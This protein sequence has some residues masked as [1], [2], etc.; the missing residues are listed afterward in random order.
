MKKHLKLLLVLLVLALTVAAIA[1]T[2]GATESSEEPALYVKSFS[3]SLEN[4]V[5]MNFKV[6]STGIDDPGSITL[7]LWESVPE[8]Y[9]KGSED[10]ELSSEGTETA[11]GYEVFKYTNLAAKDMTKCVY[12]CAY[13]NVDGEE[14]YSAPVKLSI[15]MYAYM[16]KNATNLDEGLVE[17]L[18]GMLDYGALAQTYFNHNTEFL[19]NETV[20]QLSV[21]NGHFEDNFSLGWYFEGQS[22]TLTADP[23]PKGYEFSHWENSAGEDIG[24]AEVLE[25]TATKNDTYTAVYKEPESSEG[26]EFSLNADGESY[27]VTGLGT[28][29]DTDIVITTYNGLPVTA[30]GINA[31]KDEAQITSVTIGNSVTSIGTGAFAFC[32]SLK[33]VNIGNGVTRI[34]DYTFSSCDN[35]TNVTIGNSVTSIGVQA[36]RSCTSL[37]NVTIPDS[38][39]SIGSD[40]FN[41]CE[42]L[43]SVTIGNGVTSIGNTAFLYCYKLVEVI[44]KSSL[45]ITSGATDNGYVGYYAIEVHTGGSKIVNQNNY[46]FYRYGDTNYLIDFAGTETELILPNSYNGESYKIHNYVFSGR[47]NLA[48][49]Y[50]PDNVTSIGTGAFADCDNLTNITIPD[51]VMSIGSY[52]FSGCTNLSNVTIPDGVT[53]ISDHMFLSCDALTSVT[54]PNGVESIGDDAFNGCTS[55][56][57]VTIP[58]NVTSIGNR[59]F[60]N[61]TS[62]TSITI[63]DSV[64]SIGQWA[65]RNCTSLTSVTI[66]NNVTSIGSS[67]FSGCTK[68]T[69]VTF[70]NTSGWWYS[71]DSTATSGESISSTDLSDASTAATYLTS[72]YCSRYWYRS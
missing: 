65:F 54:I 37:T 3:V 45:S 17:L 42:S 22:F 11:S 51:S 28:C 49:I 50:I 70:K 12:A 55:L 25:Y 64:T 52:A 47:S 14:I 39:T 34:R 68:L 66:G 5:F 63:P 57:N 56:A 58:D 27:T 7:L 24:N 60:A 40:A 4:A 46:L 2:V 29:T 21:A 41:S 72:T 67:A 30:I 48:I 23:A 44:N 6:Q 26:L 20:Y 9:K 61:C 53:S 69:G 13:A 43:M 8:E 15:V 71:S 1:I 16:Q 35:L 10:V 62:L 59:A 36:F 18:N 19:A 33:Y 38:V 32:K 31:F